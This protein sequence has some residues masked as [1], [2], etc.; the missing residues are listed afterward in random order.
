[1][2][3]VWSA[4][5]RT[6]YPAWPYGHLLFCPSFVSF[7]MKGLS[8][9]DIS[10]DMVGWRHSSTWGVFSFSVRFCEPSSLS[11]ET[12]L[13]SWT[14][15]NKPDASFFPEKDGARVGDGGMEAQA[16]WTLLVRV[17]RPQPPCRWTLASLFC[18]IEISSV[19]WESGSVEPTSAGN[20]LAKHC[21]LDPKI[22]TESNLASLT[23]STDTRMCEGK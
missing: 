21:F 23:P 14:K 2:P 3:W 4:V 19:H 20:M 11:G 8:L 7:K 9:D 12:H 1:M 17:E 15:L 18:C 10:K 5:F 6:V 13:W 16:S 22:I